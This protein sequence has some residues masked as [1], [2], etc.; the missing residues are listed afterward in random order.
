MQP[1]KGR[2]DGGSHAIDDFDAAND[3]RKKKEKKTNLR[4]KTEH[5]D[6]QIREKRMCN[7][8]TWV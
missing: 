7:V 5:P 1:V 6:L 4:R 3:D 8:L 2:S